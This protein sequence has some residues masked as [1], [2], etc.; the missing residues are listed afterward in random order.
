M[1]L[2]IGLCYAIRMTDGTVT[3][4][5]FFGQNDKGELIAE[6]PPNSG[7]HIDL[8][9]LLNGGNVAYWEIDCPE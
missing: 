6:S 1:K 4:F 8:T 5:R 3:T 9:R 2:R 7:Q